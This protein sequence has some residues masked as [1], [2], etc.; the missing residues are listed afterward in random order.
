MDTSHPCQ[1]CAKAKA[2]SDIQLEIMD[3]LYLALF[4][5]HNSADDKRVNKYRVGK[6]MDRA[7]KYLGPDR[8]RL[9]LNEREE[10]EG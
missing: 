4:A 10:A 9:R 5:Y 7:N 8:Y 3:E 6:V 1:C 2:L